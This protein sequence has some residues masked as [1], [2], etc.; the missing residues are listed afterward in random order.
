MQRSSSRCNATTAFAGSSNHWM[1]SKCFKISGKGHHSFSATIPWLSNCSWGWMGLPV[2]KNILALVWHPWSPRKPRSISMA[3]PGWK[4]PAR[5]VF[6]VGVCSPP[7]HPH[8]LVSCTLNPVCS[9][10]F[11]HP[12]L[13]VWPDTSPLG[14]V[15]LFATDAVVSSTPSSIRKS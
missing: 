6:T 13:G 11:A 1:R 10:R 5:A 9:K 3:G 14:L 12:A 2:T 7:K 15:C 8:V 4:L